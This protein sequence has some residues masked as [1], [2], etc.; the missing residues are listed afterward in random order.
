VVTVATADV[1][2]LTRLEMMKRVLLIAIAI[3]TRGRVDRRHG[4]G[5]HMHDLISMTPRGVGLDWS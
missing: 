1:T 2:T 5:E 4:W 3:A